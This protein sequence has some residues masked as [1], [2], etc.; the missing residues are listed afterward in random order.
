MKVTP[1]LK[2]GEI[3]RDWF[4]I[5]ASSKSLGR[6]ST[7]AAI[8]LSGK[9]KTTFSPH[10]DNGDHVIILNAANLR[11]TGR[12]SSQKKFYRHSGYPGA[13]K[14]VV[15][16][17]KIKKAPDKVIRQSIR[18]MLATNKLRDNRLARLYIFLDDQHNFENHKPKLF[19]EKNS[20]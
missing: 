17:D 18:G 19:A 10:I 12:K 5:D 2:K 6:I 11:T 13:L 1:S 8:L 16:A 9:H 14:S 7:V 4:V 3:K 15:L 20:G